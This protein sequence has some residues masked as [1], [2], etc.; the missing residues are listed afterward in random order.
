MLLE[1]CTVQANRECVTL[2]IRAFILFYSINLLLKFVIKNRPVVFRSL[3][4]INSCYS[5]SCFL[6]SYNF[7]IKDWIL[8]ILF[9]LLSFCVRSNNSAVFTNTSQ[10]TKSGKEKVRKRKIQKGRY[11]R[12]IECYKEKRRKAT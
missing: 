8:S 10:C 4:L 9:L 6:P 5:L 3:E 2:T 1:L 7:F 11:W 12:R